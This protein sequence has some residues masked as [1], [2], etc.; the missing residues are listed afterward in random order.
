MF[1]KLI[2]TAAI[3]MATTSAA[4]AQDWYV[5]GSIGILT[6][7]DSSNAGTTG[8]FTTGNGSPAVPNGTAVAAGTPYGW[9]TEFED[10]MAASV[11]AGLRY[12]GGLRS[13]IELAY[14]KADVD[15]HSGVTLGGT[16]IDG[17]DAAVLT[18]SATQLG[19]TVGAVVD[20]GRGEITNTAIFAN[21]YYDFDLG[22]G[23]KPYVGAGIG[24]A[25]VEVDYSPSG[26]GIINDDDTAFAWQL[27][28]GLTWQFDP[29]WEAYGE[30]AYRQTDDISFDNQLFPGTLDIENSQSVVSI[31][32]RYRL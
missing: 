19:A 11:E 3:A 17:V 24:F 14:S 31:G 2:T 22:N 18:G 13:G 16:V 30:Y 10:G 29:R 21:A 23:L 27:K 26:V 8:A 20:D 5:G 32:L 7:D 15:R 25:Q 9:N 12:G 28:G 6:Q 4:Y 1:R